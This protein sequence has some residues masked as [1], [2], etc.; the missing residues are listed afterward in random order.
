MK[1]PL[2]FARLAF[3]LVCLAMARAQLEK[4][5]VTLDAFNGIENCAPFNALVAPSAGNAYAITLEAEP[6]ALSS[7]SYIV[8]AGI[9]SLGVNGSFNSTQPIKVT[10]TL[11]ASALA[12]LQT[13]VTGMLFTAPGFQSSSLSINVGG[14]GRVVVNNVKADLVVV[15]SRGTA[16]V[17]VTGNIGGA[18]VTTEGT[19]EVFLSG[20]SGGVKADLSGTSTLEVDMAATTSAITGRASGINHIMYSGGGSCNVDTSFSF[21]QI[22]QSVDQVDIPVTSAAW[23]CSLSVQGSFVCGQPSS[24][25]ATSGNAIDIPGISFS[26]D[27]EIG[28]I[29]IDGVPQPDIGGSKSSSNCKASDDDVRMPVTDSTARQPSE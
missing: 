8:D 14:T 3:A 21:S 12:S 5:E 22:C 4:K 20:V 27:V 1:C 7:L 23:S 17:I 28:G 15:T 2:A 19:G 11:P 29:T 26:G 13:T 16:D 6:V 25:S 24:G 18:E 9:L 10:V